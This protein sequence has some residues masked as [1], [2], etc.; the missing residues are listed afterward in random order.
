MFIK[1]YSA[2]L[3]AV[4]V[5]MGFFPQEIFKQLENLSSRIEHVS[6]RVYEELFLWRMKQQKSLSGGEK[7]ESLD[8]LQHWYVSRFEPKAKCP[9]QL[10]V[11]LS[12][13]A[14]QCHGFYICHL[15]FKVR[16]LSWIYF[17]FLELNISIY[18]IFLLQV[19]I[20]DWHT[21]DS[22]PVMYTGIFFPNIV[23]HFK[24]FYGYYTMSQAHYIYRNRRQHLIPH[25]C[26][27]IIVVTIVFVYW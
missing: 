10:T 6:R 3:S 13:Y 19:W 26:C 16:A 23:F 22:L 27:I 11:H 9:L 7:P 14:M 15:N 2:D 1:T 21:V 8:E 17:C 24:S 25:V 5:R 12:A 18:N 4:M 20:T